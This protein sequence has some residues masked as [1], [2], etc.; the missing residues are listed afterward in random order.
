VL[1]ARPQGANCTDASLS[2]VQFDANL[3]R[4]RSADQGAAQIDGVL[5]VGA[6][7]AWD[8]RPD[9]VV[10]FV[11]DAEGDIKHAGVPWLETEFAAQFA[12]DFLEPI[13]IALAFSRAGSEP[14]ARAPSGSSSR[15]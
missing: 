12:V 3:P 15:R 14:Q 2:T 6:M 8:A 7:V 5:V 4:Q 1:R 10:F 11:I 13:G 9:A